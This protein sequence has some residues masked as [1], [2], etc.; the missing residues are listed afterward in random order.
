M[1]EPSMLVH[2]R[3]RPSKEMSMPARRETARTRARTDCGGDA[4]S[5]PVEHD[6]VAAVSA[7][8]P[9]S[10]L[11]DLHRRLAA[12]RLPEPETVQEA[13]DHREAWSQGV[14]RQE[15]EELLKYWRE[16]YD[17]RR[18]ETRLEQIG[19]VRTIIDGLGIHALHRRSS[20]RDATPLILTHGW[21]GSIAEFTH[22]VDELAEPQKEDQPA[23]HV[24]V[25]SLPGFGFSDKPS[26]TGWGIEKIAATWVTLMERLGYERFLAHGGD[27]GGPIT[28]ILG[29][30]FPD[31][32]LGIHMNWA[33]GLPDASTDRLSATER[34]WVEEARRFEETRLTYAKQQAYGAQTLGFA[35]V[36]SPV[37]QLAWILEKF[38]EWTDDG[39]NSYGSVPRDTLLDNV[40][41]YWLTASGASAAR[42]YYESHQALDPELRVD[43]P[44]AITTYPRDIAKCPRPW[45][46]ERYRQIVRWREAEYGGHF[47]SLEDPCYFVHDLRAGLTAILAAVS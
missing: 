46:Q 28:T 18:F 41:L 9:A 21:P 16:G 20:R 26:T 36:D 42:I 39:E 14:P 17:W 11:S 44:T 29:G 23:F 19:Q 22:I 27:W 24:V 34:R 13:V 35:L 33:Q 38:A 1:L 37:G 43:I 8:V 15:V 12:T 6:G 3:Q 47:A 45:A 32:V 31:R 4:G 30:R 7:Q 10:E 5:L 2:E 40:T 25:P